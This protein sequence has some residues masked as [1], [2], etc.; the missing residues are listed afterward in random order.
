MLTLI[1]TCIYCSHFF[2]NEYDYNQHW[3]LAIRHQNNSF[4]CF[5]CR[6]KYQNLKDLRKHQN[7]IHT[8]SAVEEEKNA[9]VFC[10]LCLHII[11]SRQGLECLLCRKNFQNKKTF[12]KHKMFVHS[13]TFPFAVAKKLIY[14]CNLCIQTFMSLAGFKQHINW[15]HLFQK[16]LN[17]FEC[18]LCRVT[19]TQKRY[20]THHKCIHTKLA[21]YP[22]GYCNKA[23]LLPNILHRHIQIH[24]KNNFTCFLCRKT[25]H[26]IIF[27]NSH[28]QK[29]H[30]N[31]YRAKWNC[32]VCFDRFRNRKCLTKHETRCQ[33]RNFVNLTCFVCF[34]TFADQKNLNCHNQMYHN[35]LFFE[36]FLC[37]HKFTRQLDLKSH[38][39]S[40]HIKYLP[41]S[42][43]KL[44]NSTR[45][46][47]E[48]KFYCVN[49]SD[50][51]INRTLFN[52]HLT[53]CRRKSSV[54]NLQCKSPESFGLLSNVT[55]SG[56]QALKPKH[57]NRELNALTNTPT[58][59]PFNKDVPREGNYECFLCRRIYRH[60]Y[61]LSKHT[62]YQHAHK[63]SK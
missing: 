14:Q 50:N 41:L 28:R 22:C 2:W 4:E 10:K 7:L 21:K 53:K 46:L 31:I 62:K 16:T 42:K 20:L 60:K 61:D 40:L 47:T 59:W 23:F 6:I 13:G 35:N 63:S 55:R 49:C 11:S 5:L 39:N 25:F 57:F 34:I 1:F 54:F 27:L 30:L 56:K 18:Y 15:I 12:K 3:C 9:G 32:S 52:R 26:S 48:S 45:Q 37:R 19:F 17:K 36:C 58:S 44:Q 33:K 51:F 24:F 8:T 43:G 29:M 38:F